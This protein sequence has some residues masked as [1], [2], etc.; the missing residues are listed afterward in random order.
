MPGVVFHGSG[1]V[2]DPVKRKFLHFVNGIYETQDAREIALLA[3]TF[4]HN[5]GEVKR[6]ETVIAKT[7]PEEVY[8]ESI[9]DEVNDK[10][11]R[12]RKPNANRD[13]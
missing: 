13:N 10:P 1:S 2:F 11:K 6:N 7:I 8:P 9:P 4:S 12:G 5:C 3:K